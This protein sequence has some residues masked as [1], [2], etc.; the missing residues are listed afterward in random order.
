MNFI[1]SKFFCY[2]KHRNPISQNENIIE[3]G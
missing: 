2:N 3:N 1:Y